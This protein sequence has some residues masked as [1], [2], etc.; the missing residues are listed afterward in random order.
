MDR[1]V[2]IAGLEKRLISSLRVRGGFGVLDDTGAGL[3]RRSLLWHRA[4]GLGSLDLI[5]FNESN[6]LASNTP[7][8]WSWMAYQGAINY[9]DLLFDQVEW[10]TTDITSPW[11][12]TAL[13]TWSYSR[14]RSAKPQGLRVIARD[15]DTRTAGTAEDAKI[16]LDAPAKTQLPMA[17]LKCVILGRLKGQANGDRDDKTHY[18]L[19]VKSKRTDDAQWPNVYLRAGVG[20]MPGRMIF[21]MT[22]AVGHV[23]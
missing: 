4:Q 10:E 15:F 17:A 12:T 9:L 5:P 11:A 23:V 13:G 7:P 2:A 22:G 14:D 19:L 6:D 1:P 3:L 8:S 16:V 18:V 21:D 20:F